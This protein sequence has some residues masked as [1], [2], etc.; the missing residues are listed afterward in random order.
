MNVTFLPPV[1]GSHKYGGIGKTVKQ[2]AWRASLQQPISNQIL[3]ADKMFEF[4]VEE[5]KEIDFLF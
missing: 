5:I 3:I 4:C 1:M 2:L